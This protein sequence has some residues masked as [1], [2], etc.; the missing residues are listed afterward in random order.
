MTWTYS[1]P[2]PALTVDCVVFGIDP[3]GLKVLLVQRARAPYQGLWALPGGFVDVDEPLEEAAAREL[4][5]ETGISG[6]RLEQVHTFGAPNR[7]PR[8]RVVSVAYGAL[9]NVGDH[10]VRAAT[11]ARDAGWFPVGDAHGLAFDHDTIL[12]MALRRLRSTVRFRPLGPGLLPA[13]FTWSRLQGLYETVL[14]SPLDSRRFR[15]KMLKTGLL[16]P[17]DEVPPGGARRTP[18]QVRFN[19]EKL[20][21]PALKGFLLDI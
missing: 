13:T 4:E 9:V 5:E 6:I 21:P 3:A 20:E 8:D 10:R 19:R 15:S 16:T 17:C 12:E 11:D 7:D 14:G 2:R 1:H 18:R